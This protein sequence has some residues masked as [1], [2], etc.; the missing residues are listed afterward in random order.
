MIQDDTD[1]LQSKISM[2]ADDYERT[3][4]CFSK[5][6]AIKDQDKKNPLLWWG[7]YGGLAFELQSLAKRIMSLCCSSSGCERNWSTFSQIHTKK[8]NRL[9]HKRLNKLVYVSYNRRMKTRF[10]KLREAGCKGKK[11]NPLILEEFQ[12]ENE[13]VNVHAEPVHQDGDG[14]PLTW[15]DVDSAMGAT[16][17]LRGRDFPRTARGGSGTSRPIGPHIT[18]SRKRART[19]DEE[20][21]EQNNEDT[22]VEGEEEMDEDDYYDMDSDDDDGGET[23][24]VAGPIHEASE[25]Q[26]DDQLDD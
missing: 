15:G 7:A 16:E 25:F 18:Y 13:W 24:R 19:V 14:A 23:L 20:V 17:L 9:E 6:M 26:L 8:R 3:E 10:Q 4:G 22:M 21:E 1:D 5:P 11:A 2:Q 12:W